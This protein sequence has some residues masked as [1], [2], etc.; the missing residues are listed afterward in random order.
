[1]QVIF[2]FELYVEV[3]C[4]VVGGVFL[5]VVEFLVYVCVGY[6]C[7]MCY[8]VCDCEVYMWIVVVFVVVVILVW[9]LYD[10]LVVDFVE[11]DV[12][13]VFVGCCGYCEQVMDEVGVFDFLL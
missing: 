2:D 13:C 6:V 4:G 5:F 10:C 8:Y 1:M 3:I 9:V 7:D 12:L 11:V